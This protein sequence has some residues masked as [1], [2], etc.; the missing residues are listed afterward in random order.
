MAELIRENIASRIMTERDVNVKLAGIVGGSSCTGEHP[1][2]EKET[3]SACHHRTM[4][5]AEVI[6]L[7]NVI[8]HT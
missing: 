6:A 8:F 2:D 4:S 3:P 1:P 7:F 5:E